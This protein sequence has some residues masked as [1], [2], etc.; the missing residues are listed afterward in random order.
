MRRG[1]LLQALG[2][3]GMLVLALV[4]TVSCAARTRYLTVRPPQLQ[5][6]EGQSLPLTAALM[7]SESVRAATDQEQVNCP[8][9][10]T[11]FVFQTGTAFER[12]AMQA[13]APVFSKV[14]LVR[15]KPKPGLYDLVIE[16]NTPDVELQGHCQL[17]QNEKPSLDGRS[18]VVVRVF[19]RR[20]RTLM[21]ATFSSGTHSDPRALDVVGKAMGDMLQAMAAGL[22][23]A[24]KIQSY[25]GLSPAAVAAQAA[26]PEERKATETRLGPQGV[27][28]RKPVEPKHLEQKLIEPKPLE[29]KSVEPRPGEARAEPPKRVYTPLPLVPADSGRPVVTGAG[30]AVGYG[31]VITAYHLLAGMSYASVVHH[32]RALPA[33]V[34]L[35]DRLSD[36]ALLKVEDG[37]L[38]GQ[39]MPGL[40]LGD[41]TKVKVGDRVW[42]CDLSSK[43]TDKPVWKEGR[44]R[45]AATTTSQD[46]RFF[47]LF[48]ASAPQHSGGPVLNDQG[49]VVGILVA[50]GDVEQLFPNL[51]PL[52][53][54]HAVAI[55]V[56]YA[57]W[58]LSMLPESEFV[59]PPS[60]PRSLPVSTMIENARPQ[61]VVVKSANR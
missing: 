7:V 3:S 49:E 55:K 50:Q 61:V 25:A 18:S 52:P 9:S 17:F 33:A 30:F 60:I 16:P 20:D 41:G 57:K 44:V 43:G 45:P 6:W 15:E 4:M 11:S 2:V 31:Y 19:D 37:G 59:M 14:D 27:V 39:A 54:D 58:L 48:V 10:T 13:L 23:S 36:V 8:Y 32:D 1:K 47:P 40:R 28:E 5:S 51:G 26:E 35:R 22:A 46:P 29:P 12:G 56:Q 34:V 24:P 21:D 38:E 42:A 53:P